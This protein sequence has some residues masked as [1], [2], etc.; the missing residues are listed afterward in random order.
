MKI[1]A[2]VIATNS[3]QLLIPLLGLTLLE[4]VILTARAAGID[5][6][7]IVTGSQAEE[8][9][10]ALGSGERY[11]VNIEFIV[12]R[13]QQKEHSFSLLAARKALGEKPFLLI[14]ADV[15]FEA[16]ILQRVSSEWSGHGSLLCIDR[17]IREASDFHRAMKVRLSGK[18]VL[19]I[20]SDLK[21]YQAIACG[22]FLLS[23]SIFEVLGEAE[24]GGESTL[25]DE[26]QRLVKQ[27]LLRCC[28]MTGE[29][30][31][32]LESS[33]QFKIAEKKLL[34]TLL[35][36]NEGFIS[37]K[38]DRKISL[39]ITRY[40]SSTGITPNQCTFLSFL[41]GLCS[42]G[43]FAFGYPFF[44]GIMAQIASIIDGVDG[45]IARLKFLQTKFGAYFDA[46]LDRYSDGFI[47]VGMT[48]YASTFMGS[49]TVWVLGL[50]VMMGIPMS[51]LEKEKYQVLTGKPFL[52]K[53][54]DG[55]LR[56]LP[57]NRDGRLFM[58]MLGGVFDQVLLTLWV[59]MIA[60]HLLALLRLK[61][62]RIL[63]G[64][65]E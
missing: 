3:S 6:F 57:A 64:H 34:R 47:V 59:L 31:C 25:S 49:A 14:M 30:W 32:S 13:S 17:N 2:L 46:I 12:E 61:R 40:L 16:R 22:I 50:L 52:S 26:I 23:P 37:E 43:L 60:T 27:G 35:N 29:F 36:P 44:G 20:G 10:E 65:E 11:R 9:E 63:M 48:Y 28:D 51:M 19:D 33:E 56:F 18:E 38:L 54:H 55:V 8:L 41:I 15:L 21:E 4:R 42:A 53:Y 58:I 5:E 62:V 1:K 45:E 7:I 24:Q 39:Q